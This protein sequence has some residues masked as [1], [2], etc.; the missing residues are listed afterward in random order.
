MTDQGTALLS[1]ARDTCVREVACALS[2]GSSLDSFGTCAVAVSAFS[3][4][5][6]FRT[7]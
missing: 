1:S 5:V 3:L 2:V 4:L 7:R 6:D